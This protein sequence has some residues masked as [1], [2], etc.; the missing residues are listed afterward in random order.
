MRKR[1][2]RRAIT[3]LPPRGLRRK[4]SREQVLDLALAH[5]VNLDIIARGEANDELLWQYVGGCLTWS[6]V[7]ARLDVGVPEMQAQLELADRLIARWRRTGRVAFDGP[8]YQLAKAGVLVMDQL[9]EIVDKPTAIACAEW[10]LLKMHE[11]AAAAAAELRR[12]A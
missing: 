4:L 8:D 5:T 1:C 2:R 12:A 10:G 7:A 9:A 11:M 3:P 6:D